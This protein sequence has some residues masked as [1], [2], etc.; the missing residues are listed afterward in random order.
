MSKTTLTMAD[1]SLLT[2]EPLEQGVFHFQLL[3]GR[4]EEYSQPLLTKYQILRTDWPEYPAFVSEPSEGAVRIEAGGC[5]LE[6]SSQYGRNSG[7]WRGT[8][9][10]ALLFWPA[11]RSLSG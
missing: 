4:T 10:E 8:S 6:I 5:S 7:G 2:I 11:W 3:T 1:G 9:S